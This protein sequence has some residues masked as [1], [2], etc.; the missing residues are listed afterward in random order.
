MSPY[1]GVDAPLTGPRLGASGADFTTASSTRCPVRLKPAGARAAEWPCVALPYPRDGSGSIKLNLDG[2]I[3]RGV[4]HLRWKKNTCG[5]C[6]LAC[7]TN[8]RKMAQGQGRGNL[9]S[10]MADGG[11][12]VLNAW[13]RCPCPPGS[14]APQRPSL[15]FPRS[16]P[17]KRRAS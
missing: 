16:F 8:L 15:Y 11:V 3:S 7:C 5:A 4:F 14:A 9:P 6:C 13:R 10:E 2:R 17:A 12:Q 1:I